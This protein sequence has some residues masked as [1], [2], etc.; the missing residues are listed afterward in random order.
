M[1]ERC[2]GSTLAEGAHP[3]VVFEQTTER[4]RMPTLSTARLLC[5]AL[6]GAFATGC[7]SV[8]EDPPEPH[9]R[10]ARVTFLNSGERM[11]IA[12][13]Y[14]ESTPESE[15]CAEYRSVTG[16]ALL[17][18]QSATIVVEAERPA[19]LQF[20]VQGGM[21][22]EA[23]LLTQ[24]INNA[25]QKPCPTRIYS[26]YPDQGHDYRITLTQTL[27]ESSSECHLEVLDLV[28]SPDGTA[29]DVAVELIRRETRAEGSDVCF[30]PLEPRP[31][32]K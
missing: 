7:V 3:S 6:T 22:P 19:T 8:Y 1:I 30:E 11:A 29:T 23:G 28:R 5:L 14:L 15:R 27:L 2:R 4:I 31:S 26:F 17:V 16:R 20:S 32:L 25:I 24:A 9:D 13:V 21:G 10:H 12:G 18:G